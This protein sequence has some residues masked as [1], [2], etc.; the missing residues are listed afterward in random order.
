MSQ[1]P[2]VARRIQLRHDTS[3]NW[4]SVGNSLVLLAGEFAYETDTGRLKIGDGIRN[5][6]SLPYFTPSGS[7]GPT[8]TTGATGPLGTGPTGAASNVTGPTGF[9]GATG[10]TGAA[11]DV[12]GPTGSIGPT[13]PVGVTSD[14]VYQYETTNDVGVVKH[15]ADGFWQIAGTQ[16]D[17]FEFNVV[18]Y[19]GRNQINWF[20]TIFNALPISSRLYLQVSS[21]GGSQ[22]NQALYEVTS[23][24]LEDT[25]NLYT[26]FVKYISSTTT[27]VG[28][29]G[30][31]LTFRIAIAGPTGPAGGGT[32][33][34]SGTGPTGAVGPTGPAGSGSGGGTGFTGPTGPGNTEGLIDCGDPFT[35]F[36]NDP[37]IDCGSVV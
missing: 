22:P 27:L 6:N 8:G 5:W 17:S 20:Q 12:T 29:Y 4:A 3:T 16:Q 34:S 36:T 21:S 9:T 18:D 31:L 32:G 1:C 30:S 7:T 14:L 33:G 24:I 26:L 2:T 19:Y 37:L 15:A 28:G 23:I 25:P 11:S 10:P 13:G 35:D